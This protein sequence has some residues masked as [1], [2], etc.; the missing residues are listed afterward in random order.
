[1]NIDVD[2]SFAGMVGLSEK[3]T[4][5]ALL[6]NYAGSTQVAPTFWLNPKTGV[7]YPV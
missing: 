6:T 5:D 4:A 2:R 3:D 7:S 1:L